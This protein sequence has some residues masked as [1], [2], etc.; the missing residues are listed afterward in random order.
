MLVSGWMNKDSANRM[1]LH[2]SRQ[3][4]LVCRPTLTH[5]TMNGPRYGQPEKFETSNMPPNHV[6]FAVPVYTVR[7]CYLLAARTRTE[8]NEKAKTRNGGLSSMPS[9]PP[10]EPTGSLI[11][12]KKKCYLLRNGSPWAVT[13]GREGHTSVCVWARTS[14]LALYVYSLWAMIS[15]AIKEFAGK[16]WYAK[17]VLAFDSSEKSINSKW[18]PRV[19]TMKKKVQPTRAKPKC[20]RCGECIAI[21]RHT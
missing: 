1:I 2:I 11:T 17:I 10:Y 16:K 6:M 14:N 15:I 21:L 8:S 3:V 20:G 7:T 19:P 13:K 18:F 12:E 5:W 4:L 9:L